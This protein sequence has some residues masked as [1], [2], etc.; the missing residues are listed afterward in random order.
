MLP[1]TARLLS[2]ALAKNSH[3]SIAARHASAL[4]NRLLPKAAALPFAAPLS[5]SAKRSDQF[6]LD[7]PNEDQPLSRKFDWIEHYDYVKL[8]PQAPD[9]ERRAAQ[10]FHMRAQ[11][12]YS[13]DKMWYVA[14]MIRGLSIDEAIKQLS[15]NPK[16]GARFVKEVLIEAQEKAVKEQHFEFK[17]HMWVAE[18]FCSKGVYV[19]GLRKH[20]RMRWGVIRYKW[21][22]YFVKL[23]EGAP[24]ADGLYPKVWRKKR[25]LIEDHIDALR[26]RR[27]QFS[28]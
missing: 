28:H 25:E 19:K 18:S 13:P 3:S 7:G 22:H 14:Q 24:S 27:V 11:I 16:K 1:A 15:F 10:C 20:A 21:C 8:P 26:S 23:Q 6:N 12:R 17:T 5:T 2:L 9:E 4:I